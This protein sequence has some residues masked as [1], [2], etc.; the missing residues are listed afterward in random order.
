MPL[1]P[2]VADDPEAYVDLNRRL[3]AVA[4]PELTVRMIELA[5]QS[6]DVDVV[7]KALTHMSKF[8]GA[9]KTDDDGHSGSRLPVI[10]VVFG[11]SGVLAQVQS[12]PAPLP[13]PKAIGL[14][15]LTEVPE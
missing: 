15:L 13:D 9:Y 14:P 1:P 7:N 5:A 4:L 12:T 2:V 3:A 6:G 8:T 11:S 10:N